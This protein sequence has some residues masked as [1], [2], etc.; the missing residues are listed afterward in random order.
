MREQERER[1]EAVNDSV[2]VSGM[3]EQPE[4]ESVGIVSL[5]GSTG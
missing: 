2:S 5:D 1:E 3:P 4:K